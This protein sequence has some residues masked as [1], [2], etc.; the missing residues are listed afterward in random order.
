MSYTIVQRGEQ[1]DVLGEGPLWSPRRNSVFWVDILA[2]ALNRLSLSD[3]KLE[4]WSMPQKLGWVVERAHA[5]NFIAG[6]QNGFAELTLQP[7]SVR[8]LLDPEPDLPDNRMN[9]CYVDSKGR[10]W[11]GTMDVAIERDTGS[12]YRLDPDLRATRMDSGYRVTNGPIFSL[13]QQ[14]LY[15]NDTGRGVVYRFDVSEEGNLSNKT[16]FL[17][18]APDWGVPDGMTLDSEDCLWIAHWGGG[19]VSRFRPTGQLDRSIALP[20]SQITSC[21]FAGERLDRLFVTSAAKD[22]DDEEFAGSLFEVDPGVRGL[23]PNY[24]AG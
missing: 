6:F 17:Q 16:T 24:F 13:S 2:P 9:D 21:I 5:T 18:F 20:A 14:H 23:P 1:R 22:R 3:G 7:F 12:L 19:R 10:L 15:H 8:P 11:A 4:R